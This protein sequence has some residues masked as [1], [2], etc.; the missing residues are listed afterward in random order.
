VTLTMVGKIVVY[1]CV[2]L[3]LGAQFLFYKRKF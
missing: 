3:L 2:L 1:V